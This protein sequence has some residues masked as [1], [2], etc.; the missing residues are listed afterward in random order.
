VV[1]GRLGGHSRW[2]GRLPHS[3]PQQLKFNLPVASVIDRLAAM[4]FIV[5]PRPAKENR[6]SRAVR[7]ERTDP[8]RGSINPSR[9][10]SAGSSSPARPASWRTSRSPSAKRSCCAP[11]IRS[12]A[13]Y[14]RSL[15]GKRSIITSGPPQE[16]LVNFS[17]LA[18]AIRA[19]A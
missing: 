19:A 8:R 16:G 15:W 2:F 6:T 4:S 10:S 1:Y 5:L 17:F 13:R 12:T 14:R 7:I 11:A 3:R 9:R 18:D